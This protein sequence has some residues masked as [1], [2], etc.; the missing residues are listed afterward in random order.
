MFSIAV[1]ADYSS[2]QE[3]MENF[4]RVYESRY[5]ESHPVFFHGSLEDAVRDSC[6]VK[7]PR[8]SFY[9]MHFW[10]EILFI[11]IVRFFQRKPLLI[12]LHDDNSVSAHVFA[13]QVFATQAVT[14]FLNQNFVVWAWDF[15][16]QENKN[17]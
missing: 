2:P 13:T 10:D 4:I 3:A 8:V 9:L 17:K 5:G 6:H 11:V 15:T 14:D 1:P 12:Y 16:L 7:A